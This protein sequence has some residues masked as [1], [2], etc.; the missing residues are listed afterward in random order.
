MAAADE[1]IHV[2]DIRGPLNG[3]EAPFKPQYAPLNEK[4]W[5][6]RCWRA[7][8]MWLCLRWHDFSV[9]HYL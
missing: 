9:F 4:P 1:A 5:R 3:T 2:D 6:D 7:T 8:I